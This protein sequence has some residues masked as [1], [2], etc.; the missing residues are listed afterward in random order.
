[1]W[2]DPWYFCI[3]EVFLF[4]F[5]RPTKNECTLLRWPL[6]LV[7]NSTHWLFMRRVPSLRHM[8]I[9]NSDDFGSKSKDEQFR[10]H[11]QDDT[12]RW[13]RQWSCGIKIRLFFEKCRALWG[14]LFARRANIF[15]SKCSLNQSYF[16]VTNFGQHFSQ[17]IIRVALHSLPSGKPD[18]K[19]W[20]YPANLIEY[21]ILTTGLTS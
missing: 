18:L 11:P 6:W 14:N 8:F 10:F 2:Y 17:N 12:M 1:M 16:L 3:M 4:C 19:K 20:H 9:C 13:L 5:F 7:P 15:L 21:L